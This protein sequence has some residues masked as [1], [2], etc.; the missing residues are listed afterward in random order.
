MD[1]ITAGLMAWAIPWGVYMFYVAVRAT[2]ALFGE[3]KQ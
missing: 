3:E 1:A 2:T